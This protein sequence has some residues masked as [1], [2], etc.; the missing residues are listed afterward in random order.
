M[1]PAL[2]RV[3]DVYERLSQFH[4]VVAPSLE[5][6]VDCTEYDVCT[7]S[8]K[9]EV[10]TLAFPNRFMFDDGLL[11]MDTP[12]DEG[13]ARVLYHAAKEVRAQFH[14]LIQHTDKV[15]ADANDTLTMKVHG[16]IASY[17]NYQDFLYGLP[18]NNGGIYIESW[19]TFY[20]YQRT[21][22][23]SIYTL[24]E[25]FRHEYM[26][27]LAS[28]FLIHGNFGDAIYD[29]CRLT[30]FDEGLAEY[31]AG[32]TRENGIAPRAIIVSGI[33]S[34]GDSRMTLNETISACYTGG[35]KFYRYAGL[36]FDFLAEDHP[37][38]L[39]ALFDAL[40]ANDI[41]VFDETL[42]TFVASQSS[43]A[44]YQRHIDSRIAALDELGDPSTSFPLP[45]TLD[46]AQPEAIQAGF[47]TTAADSDADCT[48][49][50]TGLDRRFGCTGE[51]SGAVLAAPERATAST[52][53]SGSLDGWLRDAVSYADNFQA[54]V[55][56]FGEI[57]FAETAE[58][59]MPKTSY[60]LSLIHI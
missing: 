36:L 38:T 48:V 37:D 25:L 43:E 23:E 55:C 41:G 34:D 16:S 21:P 47:R 14:R 18:T 59:H 6:Y 9:V 39:S 33:K 35:F 46:K 20:T 31:L 13:V 26:H 22:N 1:I 11:V 58:G 10:E 49:R 40:R 7:E 3:L 45:R 19:G 53:L 52:S 42:A 24:E 32:S 57:S 5:S 17:K 15:A 56:H 4:L 44:D 50:H 60:D 30:W 8:L 12:L 54:M 28:R 29:D 2:R 27:Y 51:L